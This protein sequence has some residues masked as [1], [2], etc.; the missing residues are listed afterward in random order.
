MSYDYLIASLANVFRQA[1]IIKVLYN[2]NKSNL[3]I[4]K[5]IGKKEFYVNDNPG[6][7]SIVSFEEGEQITS[8]KISSVISGFG[9]A[10]TIPDNK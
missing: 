2:D 8:S 10:N 4:S 9:L 5:I 1:Y 6:Y 3:E 7:I